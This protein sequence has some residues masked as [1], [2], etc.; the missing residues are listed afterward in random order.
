MAMGQ[1]AISEA[2][3]VGSFGV[4]GCDMAVAV[5]VAMMERRWWWWCWGSL[6]QIG[7]GIVSSCVD[8]DVAVMLATL[9]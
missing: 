6:E 3:A 1:W 4:S 5:V 8:N 9:R 7:A 2:V